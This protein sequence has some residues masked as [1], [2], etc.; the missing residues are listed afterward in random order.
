MSSPFSSCRILPQRPS[1]ETHAQPHSTSRQV[2]GNRS[3]HKHD[4]QRIRGEQHG[5]Q[6]TGSLSFVQRLLVK[7]RWLRSEVPEVRN[8]MRPSE[9][10]MNTTCGG[11]V[12]E[13]IFSIL[14]D[15][16]YTRYSLL[17]F[18]KDTD[19]KRRRLWGWVARRPVDQAELRDDGWVGIYKVRWG[20]D[21]WF[22]PR[23]ECDLKCWEHF[24]EI[25]K[26]DPYCH[27]KMILNHKKERK[28]LLI[29]NTTRYIN[30]YKKKLL[31]NQI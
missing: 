13:L 4:Y 15:T 27:Y 11:F 30:T 28:L 5:G 29:Y 10:W 17:W 20:M 7:G 8:T 12:F 22:R 9:Q 24:V 2:G 31:V 25:A 19:R 21:V 3:G 23:L 14:S 16:Y 18:S 6:F 26:Q 1:Q